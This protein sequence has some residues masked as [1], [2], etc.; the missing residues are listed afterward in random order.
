MSD[1]K[2][3]KDFTTTPGARTYDDGPKSGQEFYEKV[4]RE[5]YIEAVKNGGKLRIDLDG[6]DGYAS[7][8]L[9][10]AF[11]RLGNE[12]GSDQV[13]NNIV[14]ISIEVPKYLKKSKRVCV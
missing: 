12:F 5:R 4:L 13:W 3:A 14:V 6:T 10:E 2:I 9:N 11:S 1:I 7:S 8:F